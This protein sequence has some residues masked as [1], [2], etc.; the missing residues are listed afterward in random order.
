[1]AS[2]PKGLVLG[3]CVFAGFVIHRFLKKPPVY[4]KAGEHKRFNKVTGEYEWKVDAGEFQQWVPDLGR[5]MPAAKNEEPM[6]D[7]PKPI[8]IKPTTSQEQ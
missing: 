5:I 8:I 1:M 6:P 3:L 4:E 2:V 7:L